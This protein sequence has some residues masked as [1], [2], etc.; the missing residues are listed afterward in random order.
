MSGLDSTVGGIAADV[1]IVR[2]TAVPEPR[3]LK[4]G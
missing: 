3:F 1:R 4:I 2:V